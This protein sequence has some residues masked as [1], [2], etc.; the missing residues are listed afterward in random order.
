M[1]SS[2]YNNN[3]TIVGDILRVAGRSVSAN[4]ALNLTGNNWVDIPDT[5]NAETMSFSAWIY[6]TGTDGSAAPIFSAEK[7]SGADGFAY[8][9]Q[10]T[11]DCKLRFEVVAPFSTSGAR[12]STSPNTLNMNQWYNVVATYDGVKTKIYID[13]VFAQEDTHGSYQAINTANDIPVGIGHLPNWSV[14]WFKGIIDDVRIYEGVLSLE[15]IET[16][17]EIE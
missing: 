11:N 1:D 17:A 6:I 4:T 10:I 12:V 3:G 8:R 7:G 2:G 15:E 5:L 16:L 14:Q 13:G 9:M